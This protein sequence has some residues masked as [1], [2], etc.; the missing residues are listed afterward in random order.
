[1]THALGLDEKPG[2]DIRIGKMSNPLSKRE[3]AQIERS[4]T[5]PTNVNPPISGSG[6]KWQISVEG[7]HHA[8]FRLFWNL[9]Q[10][11]AQ[12]DAAEVRFAAGKLVWWK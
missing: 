3:L 11:K 12:M 4:P 5:R 2:L 1:L 8:V 7:L 6:S 9:A 10:D